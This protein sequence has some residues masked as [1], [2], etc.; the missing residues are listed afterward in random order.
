VSVSALTTA[1]TLVCLFFSRNAVITHRHT[2][3]KPLVILTVTAEMHHC[4]SLCE[5]W[6]SCYWIVVYVYI[7]R[8][9]P[10]FHSAQCLHCCACGSESQSRL[11]LSDISLASANR[12]VVAFFLSLS[13]FVLCE[14]F[15]HVAAMWFSVLIVF[16]WP[17]QWRHRIFFCWFC[18]WQICHV[19]LGK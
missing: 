5:S 16:F 17:S 8:L 9:L 12:R 15:V 3:R 7:C 11:Y 13:C 6:A 14:T 1:L 4:A 2:H 19:D 10:R 18:C